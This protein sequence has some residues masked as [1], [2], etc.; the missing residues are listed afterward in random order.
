M[1]GATEL[2]KRNAHFQGLRLTLPVIMVT[3]KRTNVDQNIFFCART[4]ID[5]RRSSTLVQMIAEAGGFVQA[6]KVLRQGE[7]G[8]GDRAPDTINITRTARFLLPSF[9]ARGWEH[10]NSKPSQES[11]R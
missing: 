7:G 2:K 11:N 5:F 6:P 3:H 8:G 4:V 10:R 1:G 9:H